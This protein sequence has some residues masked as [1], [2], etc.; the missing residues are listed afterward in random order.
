MA[1]GRGRIDVRGAA[2]LAHRYIGLAL[3]LFLILAGLTGSLLVFQREIDQGL[4]PHLWR[5]SA[6]GPR[7]SPDQIVARISAWDPRVQARWIPIE[8]G[9]A[10]DVWVDARIDP[11]TGA[12]YA[13]G[14][15]QVFVDPVSG[16]INGSR[17]YG[18]FTLSTET[19]VPWLD[20][21]HRTL[22]LPGASG[23]LLMGLVALVWVI[24]CFIGAYL[25][26]PKG[27][28]FLRKWAPAWGL[29]R[30]GSA[31]RLTLDWHRAAGLW[32]W[33]VLLT[34]AVS[35]VAFN[36]EHQVFEPVVSVFSPIA[37]N[38]FEHAPMDFAN[39]KAPA[40]GFDAAI[41]QARRAGGLPATA[42]SSGL[43]YAPEIGGYGVAFGDAWAPGLGPTWVYIDGTTGA[44]IEKVTPGEG[45][46]G[47]IFAQAQLPLHS[48]RILGLPGRLI[49]FI[50][51]LATVGL[52]VT[53]VALWV[54]RRIASA[55][56]ERR[57][58]PG[59][60]RALPAE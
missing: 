58:A 15:N 8:P 51:G 13:V 3:A 35:G 6:D 24:D 52:T 28:P 23:T 26:L 16:E 36:L 46:A 40:F 1:A 21:F 44:L 14:F 56:A 60:A 32:L 19:L 20:M 11:A 39:P 30:G 48:G 18:P 22:T 12:P 25:T 49:I 53:G 42:V 9:L 17:P 38:R 43:Y 31:A 29:K 50:A 59:A 27:R 7:L 41:E 2:R 45:T 37:E 10:P 57:R 54:R 33:L 55:R 4:N 5:A 47:T 34:L